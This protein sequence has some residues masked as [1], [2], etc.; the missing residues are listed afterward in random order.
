MICQLP[1]QTK[2]EAILKIKSINIDYLKIP[3][4]DDSDHKVS[5]SEIKQSPENI[6]NHLLQLQ[7][8]HL[9]GRNSTKLL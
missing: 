4:F 3:K 2:I 8:D 7:I 1:K 9:L 6:L 5:L